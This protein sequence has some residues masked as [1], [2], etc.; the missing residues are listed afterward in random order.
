MKLFTLVLMQS[1]L[2][3]NKIGIKNSGKQSTV[4]DK[5]YTFCK[6]NYISKMF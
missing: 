5:L 4:F 2:V 6:V 1:L 3:M